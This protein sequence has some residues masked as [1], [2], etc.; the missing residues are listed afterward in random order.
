MALNINIKDS[1]SK[2]I[3][4]F[5]IDGVKMSLVNALR[6]IMISEV[7]TVAFETSDFENSSIKITENTSHLIMNSYFTVGLILIIFLIL[8]I[9]MKVTIFIG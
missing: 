2:D 3:L 7:N 9:L 5:D 8:I 6:R 1:E 4:Q